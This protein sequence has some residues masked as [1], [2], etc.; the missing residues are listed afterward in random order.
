MVR[1]AATV[2]RVLASALLVFA[3]TQPIKIYTRFFQFRPNDG[4]LGP[5]EVEHARYLWREVGPEP[6]PWFTSMIVIFYTWPL[7][8]LLIRKLLRNQKTPW[9]IGVL[10][11]LVGGFFLA[12]VL[13][14]YEESSWTIHR[15]VFLK[16]SFGYYFTIV[17]YIIYMAAWPVEVVF[18]GRAISSDIP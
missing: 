5:K 3:A 12:G 16:M 10:E 14:M 2:M 18:G 4:S 7:I 1:T 6:G 15:N 11:I 17:G 13:T 8:F 9:P